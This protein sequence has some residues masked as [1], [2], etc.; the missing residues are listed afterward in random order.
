[1]T[2]SPSTKAEGLGREAEREH[3]RA[4]A[5][6]LTSILLDTLAVI[7]I[8]LSAFSLRTIV[9]LDKQHEVTLQ[10][11][12]AIKDVA[13]ASHQVADQNKERLIRIES[14]YVPVSELAEVWA[15]ISRLKESVI[16]NSLQVNPIIQKTLDDIGH[17]LE[18]IE[19]NLMNHG[20]HHP[21]V[22]DFKKR[23]GK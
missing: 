3:K 2:T 20:P 18:G 17:R 6:S 16:V 22:L 10:A 4:S 1:M 14:S 21:P 8:M 5:L 15:A 19:K 12:Q 9:R 13:S 7:A 23:K 11:F